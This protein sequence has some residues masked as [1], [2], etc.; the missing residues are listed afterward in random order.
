MPSCEVS[1]AIGWVAMARRSR[2]CGMQLVAVLVALLVAGAA[3]AD[4]DEK[5]GNPCGNPCGV[6]CVYASPPPPPVYYPPP[7]PP[8]YSPPPAPT[9]YPPTTPEKPGCPPPP[10]GGGYEPAPYTPGGGGGYNPAPSTPGGGYNPT[11][12]GWYTP[13]NQLPSYNTPPGTLYPQDPGFRPN[14]A[15]GRAA[16]AWR[17]VAAAFVSAAVV[18]GALAL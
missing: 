8:V 18:A 1:R 12:S 3:V 11:P 7:P 14:G 13:P 16:D 9:Y 6:P 15:P 2:P 10:E 17:A 5:C 4:D